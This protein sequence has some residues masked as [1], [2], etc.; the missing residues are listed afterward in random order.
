MPMRLLAAAF[1]R[2]EGAYFRQARHSDG[3]FVH[4]EA[5]YHIPE[6]LN[7]VL[8]RARGDLLSQLPLT[9]DD[10][11]PIR[12]MSNLYSQAVASKFGCD[13]CYVPLH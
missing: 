9:G 7:Q 13:W 4:L 2:F 6:S 10:S 8:G 5:H 11:V 1:R 3:F 12:A